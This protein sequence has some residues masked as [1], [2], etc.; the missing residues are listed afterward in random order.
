MYIQGNPSTYKELLKHIMKYVN[1]QGH[2]L[3]YKQPFDILGFGSMSTMSDD[4]RC[5][6]AR[7]RAGLADLATSSPRLLH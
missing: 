7:A 4:K 2:P 6:E 3:I 1:V 5:L